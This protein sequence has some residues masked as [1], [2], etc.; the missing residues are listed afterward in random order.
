MLDHVVINSDDNRIISYLI[1]IL[2]S[3]SFCSMKIL[4][5]ILIKIW[6]KLVI[7][8]V[9]LD[10]RPCKAHGWYVLQPT[11]YLGIFCMKTKTK[12]CFSWDKIWEKLVITSEPLY[13]GPCKAHGQH[14]LQKGLSK[15]SR[16]LTWFYVPTESVL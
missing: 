12:S 16:N 4:K 9:L 8:L 13:A 11:R 3:N 14:V 5:C 7:T 10:A 15:I 2:Y 1:M 6:E